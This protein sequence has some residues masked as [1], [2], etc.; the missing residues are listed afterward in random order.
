MSCHYLEIPNQ[1]L[2]NEH[3]PKGKRK[4]D[5][6]TPGRSRAGSL[7]SSPLGSAD[8]L[9]ESDLYSAEKEEEIVPEHW[10]DRA[11]TPLIPREENGAK[12][13]V[14]TSISLDSGEGKISYTVCGLSVIQ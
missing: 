13:P 6:D 1:F 9:T 8:N 2:P 10:L 4:S 5:L 14:P 12:K 3:S 11:I 7:S